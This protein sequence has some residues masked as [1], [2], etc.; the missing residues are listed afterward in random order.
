MAVRSGF[1]CTRKTFGQTGFGTYPDPGWGAKIIIGEA[2][3]THANPS[4]LPRCNH[5]ELQMI[6]SLSGLSNKR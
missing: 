6:S 2:Q 5:L 3:P 1:F 4:G